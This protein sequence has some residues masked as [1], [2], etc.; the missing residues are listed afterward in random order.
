MW[1]YGKFIIVRVY[2]GGIIMDDA[3]GG[4]RSFDIL[5]KLLN[6]SKGNHRISYYIR[7]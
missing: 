1:A 3:P 7:A 5:W 6:N 2:G 4:K